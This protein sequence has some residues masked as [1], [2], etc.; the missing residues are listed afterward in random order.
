MK[1][2]YYAF[3]PKQKHKFEVKTFNPFLVAN[4]LLSSNIFFCEKKICMQNLTFCV[5]NIIYNRM[6]FSPKN[7]KISVFFV[8]TIMIFLF[9]LLR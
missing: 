1:I 9:H 5:Y 6:S 8:N 3:F 4:L 7:P 2:V